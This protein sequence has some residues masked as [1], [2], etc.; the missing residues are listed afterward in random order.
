[1]VLDEAV[2]ERIAE[3]LRPLAS[4]WPGIS[5]E[6]TRAANRKQAVVPSGAT[7]LDPIGTAP[8]LVV[9][10]KTGEGPTVV[11]LPGPPR[12]LQQMWA[13]AVESEAFVK[14][15]AGRTVYVQQMLRLYGLPESQIAETLRIAASRGLTSSES[16]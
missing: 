8:G 5:P 9:T 13:A 7:V 1:M 2:E 6:T 14:A 15:V 10:G 16:R 12:E 11:V 4:R 3:I